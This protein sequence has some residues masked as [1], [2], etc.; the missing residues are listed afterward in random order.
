MASISLPWQA[1][2][3]I[4]KPFLNIDFIQI[5]NCPVLFMKKVRVGRTFETS[6]RKTVYKWHMTIL[7][8]FCV[9]YF[10]YWFFRVYIINVILP[11][12]PQGEVNKDFY[13]GI[14]GQS[15]PPTRLHPYT[16][17]PMVSGVYNCLV[18]PR[19]EYTEGIFWSKPF[20]TPE[21]IIY[22]YTK[23]RPT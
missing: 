11:Y 1:V 5:S 19:P 3:S 10:N 21:N 6:V 20:Y 4:L 15:I 16:I 23:I 2:N 14:T 8:H 17:Q 22:S 7:I 12:H 18:L 9:L 13:S